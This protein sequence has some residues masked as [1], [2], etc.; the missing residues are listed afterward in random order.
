MTALWCFALQSWGTCS[1]QGTVMT[2][3]G[4]SHCWLGDMLR[5]MVVTADGVLPLLAG[6]LGLGQGHR[7]DDRWCFTPLDGKHA[8][9]CGRDGWWW[10]LQCGTGRLT[11]GDDLLSSRDALYVAGTSSLQST[12][13]GKD[14]PPERHASVCSST[15]GTAD[16]ACT[17]VDSYREASAFARV[18]RSPG[19]H[20]NPGGRTMF[21]TYSYAMLSNS[22]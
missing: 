13:V 12:R 14:G 20:C 5:S 21:C 17:L 15:T 19:M 18:G 22:V 1:G 7:D 9:K 4:V 2:I 6:G 11:S 8:T 16:R 3:G 10:A